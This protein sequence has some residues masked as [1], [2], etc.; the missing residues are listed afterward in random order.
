MVHVAMGVEIYFVHLKDRYHSTLRAYGVYYTLSD[1][2]YP[3]PVTGGIIQEL[4]NW[5]KDNNFGF[6]AR[7]A[8]DFGDAVFLNDE[9]A[10]F[11]FKLRWL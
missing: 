2:P 4:E 5:L 8:D 7:R 11:W 10:E 9:N 6:I 1:M 3:Q